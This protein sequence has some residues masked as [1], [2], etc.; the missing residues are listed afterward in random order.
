MS[1][2]VSIPFLRLCQITYLKFDAITGKLIAPKRIKTTTFIFLF[3]F[4]REIIWR[5][6]TYI[7]GKAVKPSQRQMPFNSFD[8]L[9][10]SSQKY[11]VGLKDESGL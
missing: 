4:Y 1:L 5:W 10:T 9:N 11:S 8:E 3:F 2:K 7:D 6:F